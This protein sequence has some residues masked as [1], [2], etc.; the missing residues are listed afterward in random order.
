MSTT[1]YRV[2]AIVG[3]EIPVVAVGCGAADTES[4]AAGVYGSAGVAIITAGRVVAMCA[5][6]KRRAAV[7]RANV[8][9][10]AVRCGAADTASQAASVVGSTGTAV[11]AG[12]CVVGVKAACSRTAA[13]IGT[14]VVVIAVGRGAA[15]THAED[16]GVVGGARVAVV[17][18][19]AIERVDTCT[20]CGV[21]AVV[22]ANIAIIAVGRHTGCAGSRSVA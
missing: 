2:T 7:I 12:R 4:R 8:A 5:A 14:E 16:A 9:I 3:A 15:S 13:V 20:G 19:R 21:A 18:S 10:V 1:R 17:A 6:T 22:R 11:I